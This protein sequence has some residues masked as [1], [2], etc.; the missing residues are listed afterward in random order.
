MNTAVF[1]R[2]RD[3]VKFGVRHP[4]FLISKHVYNCSQKEKKSSL[5]V[6][7]RLQQPK[8]QSSPAVPPV[9]H[10]C[11]P[12]F[13]V[14]LL[15]RNG[16]HVLTLSKN[17]VLSLHKLPTACGSLAYAARSARPRRDFCPQPT[18]KKISPLHSPIQC[19]FPSTETIRI[20][21]TGSLELP[22]GLS[23]SS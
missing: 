7:L 13:N 12:C 8:E 5:C 22:P 23:H 11:M 2:Y 10:Q 19:C 20:S 1:C 18:D 9:Q 17:P 16:K 3:S 4:E 6:W 21:G 15:K 14:Q